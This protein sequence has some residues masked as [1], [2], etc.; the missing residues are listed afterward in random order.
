MT[1]LYAIDLDKCAELAGL[2]MS[3]RE[4]ANYF[5]ISWDTFKRRRDENQEIDAAIQRGKSTGISEV[6]LALKT[7]ALVDKDLQAM[8]LY[9]QSLGDNFGKRQTIHH[10]G[11]NAPSIRIT[12]TAA[13]GTQTVA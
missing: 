7:R 5:G 9:L 12:L 2:G 10:E 13:D 3:I 8:K 11:E 6:A 4:I 1:R